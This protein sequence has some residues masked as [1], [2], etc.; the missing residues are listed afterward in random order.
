LAKKDAK[1]DGHVAVRQLRFANNTP[2]NN[3]A[4]LGSVCVCF[5]IFTAT[6]PLSLRFDFFFIFSF[7]YWWQLI[8]LA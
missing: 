4:Q 5:I 8:A 3:W 7:A 1:E 2:R 6:S